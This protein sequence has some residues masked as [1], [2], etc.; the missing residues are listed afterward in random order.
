MGPFLDVSLDVAQRDSTSLA[1]CSSSYFQPEA[2]NGLLFFSQ[3]EVGR[4]DVKK[5][6]LL[7]LPNVLYFYLK[8]CH[9][10]TKITN[11]NNFRVEFDCTP[12][13]AQFLISKSSWQD[14]FCLYA[15]LIRSGQ[16]N[17]G[18]YIACIRFGPGS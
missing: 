17:F 13:V 6:S 15:G 3:C 2:I 18:Q 16:T 8:R 4:S 7:H 10:D 12:F 1:A 5:F 11:S 14:R 9:H